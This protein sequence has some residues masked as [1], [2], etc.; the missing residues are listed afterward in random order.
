MVRHRLRRLS[1]AASAVLLVGGL[2]APAVTLAATDSDH[3]G[4]PNTWERTWSHTSPY[5]ADSNGNGVADGRED[6]DHAGL[7]NRQEYL[8]GTNPRRADTDH[9]GIRDGRE[10]PDHDGLRNAFEFLAGTSP[11]HADTD[12]DGIRDGHESPD[13]DGL[14]NL[15]E[16]RIGTNPRVVDT[17][18]D[19]WSDGA[20]YRAGTDPRKASSHP[21]AAT[22]PTATPTPTPTPTPTDG[23]AGGAGGA[24]TLAGA[25][26]CPIFPIDNVWNRPID[27]RPVA[28][29]SAT[30]IDT[31]GLDRGLHMDFGSYAGYG[32]PYQIVTASTPRSTVTFD[33]DEDSDHVPYPIPSNPLQEAG[34]DGHILMVDK[35]ACRLYELFDARQAGGA[36]Q[37]GS[38]ATWDLRSNALRPAG[39]TSADAAGLPILPGLVRYEEVA[40]GR[41]AHALRFTTN[42]TRM[43]YI[44]PATHYAS[45]QTSASLPPMGLRVRLKASFD[46]SRFS[47]QAR[48][49]ADALKSY[50]MILADNGSPWYI[51]G[52]SDP[53][54]DDDVMHEL[55]VVTGRDLEVVD[56]TGLVNGS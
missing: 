37:A 35:D 24:P 25:P 4:L 38:G 50:G 56:T 49:I 18:H 2:F 47:P 1:I 34:S 22:T 28:S 40:A 52:A 30:M 20:E 8:S 53:H 45:S 23:G 46:T 32:I 29:D 31:I 6:P 55:D 41:I 17:D 51:T 42:V 21:K 33:Y 5:R 3:D 16:Q 44:Y 27:T 54:F 43:A 14:S 19:G 48:V 12:H 15:T 10:D 11:R 13:H 26:A 39:F 9:D 7:T 36:W